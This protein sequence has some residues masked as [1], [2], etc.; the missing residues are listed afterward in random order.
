MDT[1]RTP[2][3]SAKSVAFLAQIVHLR[4]V[5]HATGKPKRWVEFRGVGGLGMRGANRG[6]LVYV[7]GIGLALALVHET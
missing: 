5:R 2:H 1:V 6:E 7:V 4:I 3:V